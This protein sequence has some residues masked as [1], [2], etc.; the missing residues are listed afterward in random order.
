M[1]TST[2]ARRDVCWAAGG[3]FD[4]DVVTTY[5]VLVALLVGGGLLIYAAFRWYRTLRQP[6]STAG[7]DLAQLNLT[8]Q[9]QGL[10]PEELERIR[11]AIERQCKLAGEG[12]AAGQH[13]R[14]EL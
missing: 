10:A 8:L 6:T 2:Q 9:E 12:P 5:A 11:A 1:T 14:G 13:P 7:E 3:L 4:P